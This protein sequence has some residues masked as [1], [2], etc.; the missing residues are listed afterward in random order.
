MNNRL[1][2]FVIL[3]GGLIVAATFTFPLWRPL[4]VNTVVDETLPGLS[5][6]QQDRFEQLPAEAQEMYM[7]LMGT[8]ATMGLAML[9][10]ATSPDVIVPEAEQAIPNMTDPV[11]VARGKFTEIDLIHK[12][13][14]TATIYQLADNSRIL[15]LENFSVTN[16]PDLRVILTVRS[17]P[18]KPEEVGTDYI[19]LGQLKGNI[20]NQ[21]YAVPAEIDLNVYKGVVIYCLRFQVIFST[22][23]LG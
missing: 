19:E 23:S 7:E 16:G 21:N 3:L 22:A 13:S 15:R 17:A 5:V 14:G 8:D 4:L 20:G 12:G 9:Q 1:R 11:I 18:R 10:A 2:I 6:E